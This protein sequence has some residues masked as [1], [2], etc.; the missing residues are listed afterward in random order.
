MTFASFTQLMRERLSV[1]MSAD[2]TGIIAVPVLT[3]IF[4]GYCFLQAKF[5]RRGKPL[6]KLQKQMLVYGT[7][8]VFGACYLII[9]QQVLSDFFHSENA[10]KVAVVVWGLLLSITA[11]Q[12]NRRVRNSN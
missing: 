4:L 8:F 6:T 11:W 10:W 2:A 9:F 12:R 7:I 1:E 5:I 3:L